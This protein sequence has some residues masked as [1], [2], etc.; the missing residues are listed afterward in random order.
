LEFIR[1][2]TPSLEY[3]RLF[4]FP[5]RRPSLLYLSGT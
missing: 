5:D 3:G 1:I 4:L 2:N